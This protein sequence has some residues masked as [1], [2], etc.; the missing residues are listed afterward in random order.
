MDI[1][2]LPKV[3]FRVPT[4]VCIEPGCVRYLAGVI[5][6]LNADRVTFVTDAGLRETPIVVAALEGLQSAGIAAEVIADVETNPRT[7][8]AERIA[9]MARDT[10][11]II[12]F[13]GGSVMDAAKGAAMLAT[14]PGGALD[15]VGANLFEHDPLPFVAVPTTCGTG[16]EVTWVSVLTDVERSVKVSLKGDG[17]F[18]DV[19]LVDAELLSGLPAHLIAETGL[20]A[21]TH[22]LEA[23]TGTRHNPA[24][25]ALAEASIDLTFRFL[26]RAVEDPAGDAEVRQGLARA[27]TLAGMA[28]GNSD[29]AGV[30]CLSETLGG[31]YDI[32]HGLANAVLLVPVMRYHEAHIGERLGELGRRLSLVD[33]RYHPDRF[34]DAIT[35]LVEA[36]GIPGFEAFGI[37]EA[38]DVRI[39]AGAVANGSN[40]SNPQ[41]MGEADY[42]AILASLRR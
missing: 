39:A 24:T 14:N 6:R 36:V 18:P 30:H 31:F 10:Q 34:L 25:D 32:S 19:A 23:T 4:R 42:L 22:A 35:G 11:A 15:Y 13:G 12:G 38:D 27:A 5:H 37:P 1:H 17:M 9:A 29:V 3:E 7:S 26:Q 21:L 33:S 20:D 16:S 40:G 8:T 2:Q 28:F 41:E